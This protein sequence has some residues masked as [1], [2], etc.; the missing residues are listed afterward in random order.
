M[1]NIYQLSNELLA[2]FNEIED[3]GGEITPE[4]DEQLAITQQSFKNKIKSYTDVIKML[5][6]DIVS[7]KEEKSRLNDLQKSK[8]KTI[9][10]LKKIIINAVEMFG[11]TTKS[12]SKFIDYGTGKVSIR[13]TEAIEINEESINN[14]VSRYIAGLT[15]YN[16]QNQLDRGIINPDD[17]IRYANQTEDSE[18]SDLNFSI[19]DVYKL[20][21]S[22]DLR[23]PIKELLESETGFTLAKALINFN[24]FNIKATANK[25]DIK[26]E[27]KLTHEL[28]IYAKLVE[29][30]SVTIK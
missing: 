30:Q 15:W 12:G 19:N 3:N 26:R 2:I 1:A 20:D 17:L 29:N 11:D 18:V 24:N 16:M 7:I 28:P 9:E 8:E 5:E 13:K 25:A 27:A 6:N 23:V 21:A 10:R 14:F 4:I 22:I